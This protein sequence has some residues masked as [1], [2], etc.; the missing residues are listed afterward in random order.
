MIG[1][2]GDL[3]TPLRLT[4]V[5]VSLAARV[6]ADLRHDWPKVYQTAI[7]GQGNLYRIETRSPFG[8]FIQDSDG[9]NEWIYLAEANRY[10]KHPVPSWQATAS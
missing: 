7:K 4:L 8:S 2:M 3:S 10:E 5:L 9:T 1:Q 6:N